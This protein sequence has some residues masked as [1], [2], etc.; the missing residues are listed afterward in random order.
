MQHQGRIVSIRF[1]LWDVDHTLIEVRKLH[2]V[3]YSAAFTEMF[4]RAPND[5]PDMSGRTD[6]QSST[7][8][9]QA[10]GIDPTEETL[11]LFWTK[12]I[13]KLEAKLA[14]LPHRGHATE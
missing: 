5:V 1:V 3:L 7:R 6:R 11:T 10:H 8:L 12:L 14:E 13:K 4:G 2:Y 9:L